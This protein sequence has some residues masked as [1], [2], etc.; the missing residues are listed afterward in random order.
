MS[1]MT[2]E[3]DQSPVRRDEHLER[4]F[5]ESAPGLPEALTAATQDVAHRNTN[6]GGNSETFST[7]ESGSPLNNTIP[8]RSPLSAPNLI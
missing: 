4:L 8:V 6:S 2:R 7:S 1:P 3:P 5:E